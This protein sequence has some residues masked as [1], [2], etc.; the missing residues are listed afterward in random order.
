MLRKED[1]ELLTGEA[2]FIDDLRSPAC[3]GWRIVRSP[4]AHATIN[5]DRRVGGA[6]DAGRRRRRSPAPTSRRVGRADAVR[7]AGH[8]GHQ[9]P[10][11]YPLTTDKARYVG[12]G[13]AVVVAETASRRATPPRRS[14][15]TY[16]QLP[17]VID[18]EDALADGAPSIHED[19]GTNASY[20]WTLTD[21]EVDAAFFAA[22]PV[23]VKERYVPA[24]P[25]PER[26]RAA[27]RASCHAALRRA[28]SRSGRPPRSRTSSKVTCRRSRWASPSTSSGSSRPRRRRVRLEAQ[29]LRRGG[30]RAGA[31]PQARPARQWIEERTE[32]SLATIH[33]RGQI[34]DIELAPTRTARSAAQR[35]ALA[36]MGAYLQLRHARHP[37]ARRVPLLRPLRRPRPTRSSAPACSRTSRRPTRT[38]APGGPRRRTRS[39]GRWTRCARKVGIDPAEIR[40]HELHPAVRRAD[41]VDRGLNFD[42]G[43]Y[44]PALDQALRARRLRR[45]PQGAAGRGATAGDTKQLGIGLSTLRRD[46]R[47]GAVADARGAAATRPAA[48][49]RRRSR[50]CPTGKVEVVIGTDAPRPGP[51]DHVVADRRRRLGVDAR[52]RR[53]PARRHRDRPARHGHVR[54]A[55]AAG[56]RRRA[57]LALRQGD[58]QGPHD[59]RPPAGG[60]RGR[61]RV[62]RRRVPGRGRA[63]P[64][65]D[66]SRSSRSR[67]ARPQPARRHGAGPRGPRRLRP[68]ELHRG[69]FGTH[70]CVVEVD[71]ETGAVDIVRVRRGRRL[72]QPDQPA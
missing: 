13:V 25:D 58:R 43:N 54:V 4:Y 57:A 14:T 9:D 55:L 46:V 51:R 17:A 49:R 38:A 16:E 37:A 32:N 40:R 30:P 62:R 59:R 35:R 65:D 12:D 26:D 36:D 29:R 47:A 8:R 64:G 63:R 5:V 2:R 67:R 71:T 72:R 56:R 21:G 15:S 61:P 23:V 52:R 20:T 24:A 31:G 48:G 6:S 1:P 44:E 69:P 7:L 50:A 11:H 19:L 22:A 68:A 70:I 3:S 28:S 34:Q 18:L 45:S 41:T 66:R 60:G 10:P 39:S 42:S 27:R 53:G 33:G